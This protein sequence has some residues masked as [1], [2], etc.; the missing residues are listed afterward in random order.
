MER[1][2]VL[3]G[4][5]VT[6]C[7][8]REDPRGLGNGY[9]HLL[10]G[11]PSL[12]DARLVNAGIGG[13]RLEDLAAR[14][15]RDVLAPEPDIVS[16]LIGINDTW[17]QFDS[18]QHSDLGAFADRYR[19]LLGSLDPATRIV[20]MEPFV[21]PVE[22]AQQSWR[23]DVDARIDVVHRLAVEFGATLVRT[24]RVLDRL[25]VT[26]GAGPL[27]A[28][29]VHPTTRGHGEMAAAWISAVHA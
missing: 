23:S 5:S 28:D 25:A 14:W 22:E 15:Q 9:V 3:A 29:G 17:R 21:L 1:T 8:R 12:R 10:A 11:H 2:I 24:Q 13:D 18:G 6:D 26:I 4:D 7:G 19:G 20:L 27:A 16:V